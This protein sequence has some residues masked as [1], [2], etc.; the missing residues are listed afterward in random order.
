MNYDDAAQPGM[1]DTLRAHEID[2]RAHPASSA[3]CLL[4]LRRF[5][6]APPADKPAAIYTAAAQDGIL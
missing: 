3:A 1:F 5:T 6:G 2:G 4:T